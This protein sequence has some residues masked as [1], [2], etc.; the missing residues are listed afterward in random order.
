MVDSLIRTVAEHL[1]RSSP[2]HQRFLSLQEV[3]TATNMELQGIHNIRW[4]SRGDAVLRL[5]EIASVHAQTRRTKSYLETR[6]VDC[7]DEFGGGMSAR[8]SLFIKKH[9]LDGGCPSVKVQGVDSDSRPTTH[10]F[11]LH[12]NPSEDYPTVGSHDACVDLCTAFAEKLEHNLT[13]R[14]EDLDSLTGV[15]LFTPDSWP[16]GR[17]ERREQCL[18]WLMSLVSLFRVQATNCILPGMRVASISCTFC[19]I[20]ARAPKN[21]RNIHGGLTAMLKTGNWKSSYPNLVRL[22][23]AVPVLPL[24]TMECERGFSRQNI[25]KSWQ[26]GSLK[27]ARLEDLIT[28]SLLNYEPDYTEVVQIWRSY[29]ERRHF[30][31]VAATPAEEGQG[32]GTGKE[33]AVEEWEEV[34]KE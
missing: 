31:N 17:V 9:G 21:E 19:P 5:L 15:R 26:R 7:G 28:M 27:D 30:G 22:W 33:A 14:F 25:N 32:N 6:Y 24:S 29:K 4:L 20:L 11:V 18:E 2:W 8:M 12:K 13:K 10:T 34:S 1:G 3:V 16:L 23:V